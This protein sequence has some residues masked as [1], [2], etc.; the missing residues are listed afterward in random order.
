MMGTSKWAQLSKER[1]VIVADS[2]QE[3]AKYERALN[4][5]LEGEH[6][7]ALKDSGMKV[8]EDALK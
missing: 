5:E 3:A 8:I 1:Q 7:Q 6:L 4:A 2:E